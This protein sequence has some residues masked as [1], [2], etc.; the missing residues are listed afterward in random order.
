MHIKCVRVRIVAIPEVVFLLRGFNKD[1]LWH[2]SHTSRSGVMCARTAWGAW[3][4]HSPLYRENGCPLSCANVL[5]GTGDGIRWRHVFFDGLSFNLRHFLA[6]DFYWSTE[7][8]VEDI[9]HK[10]QFFFSYWLSLWQFCCMYDE[11]LGVNS[12][13]VAS[14]STYGYVITL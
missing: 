10:L 4:T 14:S 6:F 3:L 12:D 1:L 9:I 13:K 5:M 7:C 2:T 8:V 11:Y